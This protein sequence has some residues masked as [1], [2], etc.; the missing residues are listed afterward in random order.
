M[1]KVYARGKIYQIECHVTNR[2]YIGSTTKKYLEARLRDH[3]KGHA[4]FLA[5]GRKRL[6]SHEVLKNGNYT[7]SM[8]EMYP[9]SSK[10]EL[11]A[12]E[13]HHIEATPNCVNKNLPGRGR[14]EYR[15][16][17]AEKIRDYNRDYQARPEVKAKMKDQRKRYEQTDRYKQGRAYR[18]KMKADFGDLY[19]N[20]LTA[21][22]WDVF[23]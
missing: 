21:I 2:V 10:D 4:Y 12:R 3:E 22:S 20:S 6:T 5:T 19:C 16:D 14:A 13:R 18:D 11:L 15:R 9:C 17:K 23:K 7:L 1:V 8:L